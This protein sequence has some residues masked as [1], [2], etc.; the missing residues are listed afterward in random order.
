MGKNDDMMVLFEQ[1]RDLPYQIITNIVWY[2]DKFAGTMMRHIIYGVVRGEN[3]SALYLLPDG[4]MSL[5]G[6]VLEYG[7]FL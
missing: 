3:I 5:C 7:K 6:V 1:F 4:R 2:N